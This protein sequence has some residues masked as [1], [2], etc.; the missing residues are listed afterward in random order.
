MGLGLK[1]ELVLRAGLGL[2]IVFNLWAG[3]GPQITF[4]GQAWAQNSGPCRTLVSTMGSK[5]DKENVMTVLT[6][7]FN[8]I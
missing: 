7:T 2:D 6:T 1:Y 5:M 4:A 3:P 8:K